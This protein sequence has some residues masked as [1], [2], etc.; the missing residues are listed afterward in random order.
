MKDISAMIDAL[1]DLREEYRAASAVA[2]EL[3]RRFRAGEEELIEALTS[4][5]LKQT[6]TDKA[7]ASVSTSIKPACDPLF[8][9]DCYRWIIANDYTQ[10]LIKSI[11]ATAYNELR[12]TGIQLP[13]YITEHEHAKLSLRKVK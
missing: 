10:L 5:N 13:E 7:S 6:G 4:N 1:Y 11:K 2:N 8:W 12:D 9:D 3:E